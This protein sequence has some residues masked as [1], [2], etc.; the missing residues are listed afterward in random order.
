MTARE[1]KGELRARQSI[2]RALG[3]PLRRYEFEADGDDS[4][5]YI[6]E[7]NEVYEMK[8][9]TSEEFIELRK[10]RLRWFP[11]TKLAMHWSVL[12]EAPTMSDK[13]R[14]M[15]DFPDDDP[16][17]IPTIEAE[18][19]T[20]TRKAEREA[21]WRERFS[22]RDIPIPRIGK[23]EA[24]ELE[25]HLLVLEHGGI[26]NTREDEPKTPEER[27]ARWTIRRLTHG[28]ICIAHEP[29][30][31][32]PGIE[33]KVGWG[34]P[35]TGDPNELAFRVQ[36]WLDSRLGSNLW[37]SLR[38]R[39]FARRHGVLS[40]DT[41]EPEFWSAHEAGLAFVP[42]LELTLPSE[43]DLLWCLIGSV[44]LRYE[45]GQGWQSFD[46]SP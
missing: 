27:E 20:V 1:T 46:V 31:D 6:D 45:R 43:V 32:G 28:A 18:G 38:Q 29:F 39:S 44:L 14:Q 22:G 4:L 34:Y 30:G 13:F 25:R 15:P 16:E 37:L 21:E 19:F 11:S 7:H 10:R 24:S 23:R 9:V 35:R 41:S 42:T 2:E 5:D 40:F 8:S 33:I 17:P 36:A 12:L 3:R 26:S